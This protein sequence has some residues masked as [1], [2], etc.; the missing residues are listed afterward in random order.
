MLVG[1]VCAAEH[2]PILRHS[3]R[4]RELN[5]NIGIAP[6]KCNFRKPPYIH[7]YLSLRNET[8][9]AGESSHL[10]PAMKLLTRYSSPRERGRWA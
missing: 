5:L 6:K 3:S 1:V 9:C 2:V 4:I 10:W 8:N 7:G